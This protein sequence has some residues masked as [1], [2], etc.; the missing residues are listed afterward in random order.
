MFY[1]PAFR[2]TAMAAPLLLLAATGI[3]YSQEEA[4]QPDVPYVPTPKE[5]V[6][7][8]LKLGTVK[9][10]DV[11]YDLGSGDGRI[12]ITA[13]EQLG[14][15]GVGIDIN[16]ERVQEAT[17]NARKAGVTKLV[18]FRQGDLFDVDI[19]E[20]TVVTL[21]LLPSVNL[22]LRPKLLHDLKPGTRI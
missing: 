10:G 19:S 12:V 13:A 15:R 2:K 1:S 6:L 11:I 7:A 9:P 3:A 17:E 20:A 5:V 16:P 21:Y 18:Q 8:M 22:K 14:T 4:R